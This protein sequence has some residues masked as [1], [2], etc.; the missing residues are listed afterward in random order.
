MLQENAAIIFAKEPIAG[1]VKTRLGKTIGMQ[2]A[3]NIYEQLL[4]YTLAEVSKLSNVEIYLYKTSDS[5][6]DYF[7]NIVPYDLKLLDQKGEDLGQKMS[8]AFEQV[9][10]SGAKRVIIV[11]TDC[12]AMN[13]SLIEQAFLEL[14]QNDLVIGPSTDGG[15][16][17]LGMNEKQSFLFENIAWSTPTVFAETIKIAHEN[18]LSLFRLKEYSDIDEEK[19]LIHYHYK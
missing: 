2:K 17:L 18:Q 7:R 5:S 10:L 13:K 6:E 12:P 8:N 15:Y 11:G 4:K 9:F 19:D 3:A 14:L 16:Y 1:L